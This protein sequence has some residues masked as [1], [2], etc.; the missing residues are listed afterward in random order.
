MATMNA[1]KIQLAVFDVAGTTAQDGGLVVK[2]FQIAMVSMGSVLGTPEMEKMTE[3]VMATMGQRKID[4]FMHLCGGDEERANQAHEE[5]VKSYTDLV[6]AGEL[7]EFDGVTDLFDRLRANAIAVAITTGFPREILDSVIHGLGWEQHIDFSVASSEVA[8]G[9]PAP[10]M[11]LRSI[12]LYNQRFNSK[13]SAEVIAV[14]GD[15]EA[16]MLAGVK[17]GAQIVA[18]VTTGAHTR[19]QLLASGATHILEYATDLPTIC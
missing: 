5:F 14:L 9:R 12:D 17:A 3:Y 8:H 4:V 6:K 13:I 7:A 2:A 15:T 18:G 16:D 19:D 11:I 10:D 1:K